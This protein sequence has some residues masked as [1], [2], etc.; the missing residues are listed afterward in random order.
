M[1]A[2]IALLLLFPLLLSC[3]QQS[4]DY[5]E[6]RFLLGTIVEFTLFGL[7]D[8]RM[9]E[10]V[11]Q[12]AESMQQVEDQFTIYGEAKNSVQIFNAADV[13]QQVE[14]DEKVHQLLL[15]SAMLHQQTDGAFDVT[16]GE[17]NLKWGFSGTKLPQAP[18]DGAT[19]A[20]AMASS[21][22]QYIEHLD[23]NRWRKKKK[24]L[25]L[26]FGAIA[27]GL[28]IDQAVYQLKRLGIDN[29]VINAGG[30][31]RILGH[32][33]QAPWKIAIRHPRNDKPIGWI[34]FESDESIVTSGDYERYFDY[35]D[36]RFH[37]ILDPETGFP[38]S[39]MLSVTVLANSAM[40]A[41]ALSTA[42]FVLDYEKGSLLVE[43]TEG[44]EA[45]WLDAGQ[46]LFLSSGLKQRFNPL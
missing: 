7:D 25:K 29:G 26:D 41:D 40:E 37:H 11:R 17:L 24:N 1:I 14:L 19:V 35:E 44:V 3:Q 20:Q 6:Q 13:N 12:A 46:N 33:G 8:A 4:H 39:K 16:L 28:A 42:L 5:K 36:K 38:S 31:I 45:L 30:D 22:M 34:A 21:G 27:K 15:K 2:R 43:Q 23:G 9:A 18:L 10:A 32:H